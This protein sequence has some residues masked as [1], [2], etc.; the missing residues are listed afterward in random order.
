M[1]KPVKK[2]KITKKML[3]E[4]EYSIEIKIGEKPTE[5]QQGFTDGLK[6]GLDLASYIYK[7]PPFKAKI[8]ELI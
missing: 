5:Y 1:S 7:S 3:D 6:E 8:K 2:I 4:W